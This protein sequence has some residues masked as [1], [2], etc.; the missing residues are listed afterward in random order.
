MKNL[1]RRGAPLL[2]AAALSMGWAAPRAALAETWPAHSIRLIVPFAPGGSNDIVARLVSVELGKRLGQAVVVEN[3]GGSGG[4]IGSDFVAKSPGDGYT[5]LFVSSSI[6]T[7]AALGKDLPYDPVKDLQP[8]G[9]IGSGAFVVVVGSKVKANTLQEL[10]AQAKAAPRSINYGSA[11]VGGIN[12]L[13]TELLASAAG[14]QL[15]H[16]PYKGIGLAFND[17]MAGTLQMILPSVPSA[18]PYIHDGRMRGLAVTSTQRSPLLPDLPTVAE[19]GIP[20]FQLEVWW[21]L[22]GPGKLAPDIT[23]RLNRELNEI[24]AEPQV[25]QVL[26][27]EGITPH[28][29][30][31]AQFAQLIGTDLKRWQKVVKDANIHAE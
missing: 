7:N 4:A 25:Q 18:V 16:V 31:S 17:L 19:A 30:S 12:H 13:G 27:R 8:I 5:L 15:T 10:I 28:P 1:L 24:L 29:G 23:A 3:R 9:E 2:M 22:E 21:G 6:L 14:V 26:A 11:G 20:G